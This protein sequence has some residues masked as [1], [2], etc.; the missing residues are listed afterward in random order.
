MMKFENVNRAIQYA[1]F[2]YVINNM[3]GMKITNYELEE[4]IKLYFELDRVLEV[5]CSKIVGVMDNDKVTI[6]FDTVMK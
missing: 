5:T 4:V 3:N 2:R 1:I 6:G